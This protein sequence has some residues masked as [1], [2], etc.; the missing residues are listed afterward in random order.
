MYPE[1]SG[2]KVSN[3]DGRLFKNASEISVKITNEKK[4]KI[5]LLKIFGIV[6]KFFY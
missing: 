1:E 3:I 4:F 6:F 5:L 2:W